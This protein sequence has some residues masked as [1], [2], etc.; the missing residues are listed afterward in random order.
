MRKLLNKYYEYRISRC[1]IKM[2]KLY[3][4]MNLLETKLHKLTWFISFEDNKINEKPS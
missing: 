4:E 2:A 1:A 3:N